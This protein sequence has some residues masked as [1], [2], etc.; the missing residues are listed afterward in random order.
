MIQAITCLDLPAAAATA[1]ESIPAELRRPR[2][3]RDEK[4]QPEGGDDADGH[5]CFGS[6]AHQ[7]REYGLTSLRSLCVEHVPVV[8]RIEVAS[9]REGGTPYFQTCVAHASFLNTFEASDRTIN[10]PRD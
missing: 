10:S 2:P 4:R 8:Q 3:H 6:R 5:L 7:E 1:R 9:S